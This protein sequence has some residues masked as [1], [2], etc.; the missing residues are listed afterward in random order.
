MKCWWYYSADEIGGAIVLLQLVL[1]IGRHAHIH[2]L[3]GLIFS[4]SF[5]CMC[6]R[7]TRSNSLRSTNRPCI[8]LSCG[9]SSVVLQVISEPVHNNP[10][11]PAQTVPYLP[12]RPCIGMNCGWSSL[13]LKVLSPSHP[14]NPCLIFPS[15]YNLCHQHLPSA[16]MV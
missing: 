11:T 12:N 4:S 10:V 13:A 3:P 6:P 5:S 1:L 15:F 16:F 7:C 9:W 14:H 2:T 8:G